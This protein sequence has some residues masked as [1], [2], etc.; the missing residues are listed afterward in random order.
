[1]RRCRLR[2]R[3]LTCD[4][5]FLEHLLRLFSIHAL[6]AC[7]L[8][9]KADVE[10]ALHQPVAKEPISGGMGPMATCEF[11]IGSGRLKGQWNLQLMGCDAGSFKALAGASTGSSNITGTVKATS[12]QS[13]AGIGDEAAWDGDML[14]VRK[15]NQCLMVPGWTG[16]GSLD[17]AKTLAGKAVGR[18]SK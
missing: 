4:A 7:T 16:P 8:I 13:I 12:S 3:R 17:V 11:E 2:G 14:T 15:G 10:A 1:M 18:L 6:D 5:E 9:T